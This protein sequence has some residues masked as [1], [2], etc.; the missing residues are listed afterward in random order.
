MIIPIVLDFAGHDPTG[1]AGIQADIETIAC[2]GGHALPLITT[3]TIQNTQS[4]IDLQAVDD[5][6][7]RRQARHLLSDITPSAIKIGLIS[8]QSTVEVIRETV[9]HYP[10]LP[11][12]LDPVL[13]SGS[14]TDLANNDLIQTIREKLLPI[15]TIS[16]PNSHEAKMLSGCDSLDAAAKVLIAAGTQFVLITGA[17]DTDADDHVYNRLYGQNGLIEVYNWE[18]LSACYHGSGC[19]L[20]SAIAVLLGRGFNLRTAVDQAQH[21]TWNALKTGYQI[22]KGQY[23]P[24]RRHC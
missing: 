6:W 24:D 3:Y 20:S 13:R 21:F 15:T 7:L 11:V 19:T 1:G 23:H 5:D 17:D 9:I 22:G 8:A 14:G 2:L 12:V 18:K 16:T 4:F 10:G